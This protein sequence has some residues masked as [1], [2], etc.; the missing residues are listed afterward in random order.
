MLDANKMLEHM[1]QHGL[2]ITAQRELIAQ[3]ILACG[4][5][6]NV[7]ALIEKVHIKQPDISIDT[8]YRTLSLLCETGMLYRIEKPGRGS[9][10][11]IIDG[12][13]LHY[14]I[15]SQCGYRETFEECTFKTDDLSKKQKKGFMLTG[16]KLELYGVCPECLQKGERNEKIN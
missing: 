14:M 3:Q 5:P 16:H 10:Y 12:K 11:E 9:E 8:V 7:G 4:C 13:H 1:R 2:K 15:C 6:I